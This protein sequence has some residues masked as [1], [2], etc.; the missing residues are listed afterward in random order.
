MMAPEDA[1]RLAPAEWLMVHYGWHAVVR[2]DLQKFV[3]ELIPAADVARHKVVRQATFFQQDG[4][5]LAIGG[6]PVVQIDHNC[7]PPG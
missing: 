5:L 6:G 2:A 4:Y 7:V 3:F 1:D